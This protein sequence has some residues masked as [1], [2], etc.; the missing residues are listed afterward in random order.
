MITVS[1]KFP[2]LSAFVVLGLVVGAARHEDYAT[3]IFL[4]LLFVADCM[5][6]ERASKHR[7]QQCTSARES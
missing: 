7:D 4:F 6:I 5:L 2:G 3:A 1:P